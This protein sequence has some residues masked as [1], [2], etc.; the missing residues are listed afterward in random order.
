LQYIIENKI[1]QFAKFTIDSLALNCTNKN[2]STKI[3]LDI[4]IVAQK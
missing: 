2:H 1:S 3:K 4:Y